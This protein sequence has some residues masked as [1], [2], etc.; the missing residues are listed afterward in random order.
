[1]SFQHWTLWSKE[2]LTH[3]AICLFV[4]RWVLR[5][6][7]E[8]VEWNYEENKHRSFDVPHVHV[9]FRVKTPAEATSIEVVSDEKNRNNKRSV[10]VV[11]DEDSGS[12]DD[13]Q[14][15]RDSSDESSEEDAPTKRQRL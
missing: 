4:E 9:F 7:P 10:P 6:K 13:R 11:S 3:H 1:M 8:V 15:K 2:E 5:H 12:D 14:S